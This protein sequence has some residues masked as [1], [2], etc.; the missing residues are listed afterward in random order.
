MKKQDY[1]SS[2][3][4]YIVI[5]SRWGTP[6]AS[7]ITSLASFNTQVVNSVIIVILDDIK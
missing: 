2:I 3:L 4:S 5:D 1:A 7:R 6:E